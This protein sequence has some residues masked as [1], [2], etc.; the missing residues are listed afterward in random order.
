MPKITFVEPSGKQVEVDAPAGIT[1][2]QAAINNNIQGIV[3]ECGGACQCATCHVYIEAP[4]TDTLPAVGDMEDAMLESTAA[5][6]LPTSRL[7][8]EVEISSA[9]EGLV[10]HLPSKQ[11]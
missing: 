7:G 1:L 2:L 8:C 11:F 10:V 9:M 3:G 4:W 5:D 6:R